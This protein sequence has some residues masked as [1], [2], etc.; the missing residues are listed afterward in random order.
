MVPAQV[1]LSSPP[2]WVLY[3]VMLS[4]TTLM[5]GVEKS[6]L[7]RSPVMTPPQRPCERDIE[8]CET[9][10]GLTVAL[11][12]QFLRRVSSSSSGITHGIGR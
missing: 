11:F 3:R 7:T 4:C 8:E 5:L 10:F 2:C 9:A 1:S 6:A 12:D